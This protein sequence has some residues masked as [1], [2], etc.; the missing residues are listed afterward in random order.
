MRRIDIR[1]RADWRPGLRKHPFGVAASPAGG[2]WRENARYEFTA[3]QIDH[4][5]SVADELH[6]MVLEAVRF[7]VIGDHLPGFGFS[8]AAARLIDDSWRSYWSG[9][10]YDDRDGPLVGRLTLA[11]DGGESV[12]LLEAHYD[13]APG[14]FAAAIIQQNWLEMQSPGA[15]QFN[16]LH[17]GLVE[18]WGELTAA[19]AGPA[20]GLLHL[21]CLTP[22]PAREGELAYIA[23]TAAEAGL[24]VALTPLQDVHWDG[25]C[26]RDGAEQFI[27][28]L[29]KLY[30]WQSLA[31]A[32]FGGYLTGGAVTVVEPAWTAVASNHGLPALLR[33]LYPAHPNLCRAGG[34]AAAAAGAERVIQRSFLGLEHASTRLLQAD[35][36]VLWSNDA[37][38]PQ[39]PVLWMEAPPMFEA[40][41]VTAVID[42]WIIG[43]KCMG[44]AVREDDVT[45][46][47]GLPVGAGG[48]IVPHVFVD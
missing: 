17:E 31:E 27:G 15:A 13:G 33:H 14:L 29:Y 21:S 8:R 4:I 46:A 26:L 25:R 43:G 36:G 3:G 41:G 48:R 11:F 19:A 42:A 39:G 16:A 45:P 28:R 24:H 34:D 23:G 12:K 5:E 20:Q 18:R 35:G 38:P 6:A 2:N 44:M 9:G 22:D 32:S 37:E 40:D 1:P 47:G 30:P 7:A 10:V